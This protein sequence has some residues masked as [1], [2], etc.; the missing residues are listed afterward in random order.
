[1]KIN[2]FYRNT[3]NLNLNGSI[4]SLVPTILIVG[5]NLSFFRNK[6]IMLLTIPFLLFSLLSFQV[7]IFRKRQ[8]IT[9]ERNMYRSKQKSQTI[10][11]TKFLLVLRQSPCILLYFPNG[12]LAGMI[13]KL[14]VKGLKKNRRLKIYALLNADEEVVGFFRVIDRK[15]VKIEVYDDRKNYLGCYVKTKKALRRF[16]KEL[17]DSNGRFLGIVKGASVY[18]DEQVYDQSNQNISRLRRGWMP[19]EWSP[20]FPEPNTPVLSFKEGLSETDKLLGMSFLINEYFIE[21]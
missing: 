5:A 12:Y 7:Y 8:S 14:K 11:Q 16:H 19:L 9:I 21:R 15:T 17:L 6:E 10:F 3:A 13:K 2:E 4:A 18:M 1:M 20:F